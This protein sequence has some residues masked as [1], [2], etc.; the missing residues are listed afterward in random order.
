MKTEVR[1]QESECNSLLACQLACLPALK[2]KNPQPV[3]RNV[4]PVTHHSMTPALLV[5]LSLVV[6]IIFA[7]VLCSYAAGEQSEK[8]TVYTIN[9]PLKYFA[10]RIAGDHAKVIFPAPPTVDPAYWTPGAKTISEYQHADLI[11]LNGANYAKWVNKVSLP[12][13]KLVDTSSGFKE[14]YI[15]TKERVTHTHGTEG[16]H[17][18]ENTAF[19]TWLDLMLTVKQAEA[20][21][22]ALIRKKPELK[23]TFHNN[24]AVLKKDLL[25]I[26]EE[27]NEIVAH[28]RAIPLIA[29]HP[30]YDYLFKRYGLNMKSV[31][32]EPD[33]VPTDKQWMELRNILK[34]HP[35][36]WMIWEGEPKRTIVDQLK[37]M[38][39]SSVVFDPCANVPEQGDFLSVIQRNVNNL[40]LIFMNQ[41]EGGRP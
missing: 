39:I 29:S 15:Y 30:V 10:E 3:T 12:Q 26:D 7:T 22:E 25:T 18:H 38:G 37:S 32:W 6:T 17:A 23:D 1:S 21:T 16:K 4:Q 24:Y 9:Y 14:Q 5:C 20:V 31:H 11:L 35:A 19:T 27:I 33:E 41:Y 28:N 8:L 2:Y 36:Q 13:S 34:D 40:E